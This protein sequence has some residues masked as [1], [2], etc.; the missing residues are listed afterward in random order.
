MMPTDTTRNRRVAMALLLAW[1]GLL[2]I[3][4]APATAQPPQAWMPWQ[5]SSKVD[6]LGNQ[7]DI[8]NGGYINQGT[9]STFRTAAVLT[10]NG[11][12]FNPTQSMMSADGL[13]FLFSTPNI[14][15]LKV[16]RRI[17]I[18]VNV[19]AVRYV[20]SFENLGA[21]QQVANIQLQYR[22]GRTQAQSVTT[23]LGGV[24]T[25][26]LGLGTARGVVIFTQPAQHQRTVLLDYGSPRSKLRPTFQ[27]NS[28]YQFHASFQLAV[29]GGKTVSIVHGVAQRSLASPPA[30]KE[31]AKLFK[32]FAARKWTRGV[33]G[34]VRRTIVNLRGGGYGTLDL[35]ALTQLDSLGV[36]RG[37]SDILAVGEETRVQ[38][39]AR[40]RRLAIETKYGQVEV[41]LER[42]AAIIGEQSADG[43]PRVFL[44]DG[45]I[46]FG[47]PTLDGLI[48]QLTSGLDMELSSSRLDRLVLHTSEDDGQVAPDVQALIE[49]FHGDRIA[50][51]ESPDVAI[52]VTTN[53]GQ[54]RVPLGDLLAC[55][56]QPETNG[57]RLVFADG[58]RLFA[59]MSDEV[60]LLRTV[61][62]GEIEIAPNEIRSLFA[63]Q[64]D[65]E[66]LDK[67]IEP[68]T[69]FVL[70]A[71]ENLLIGQI[72]SPEVHISAGG[73]SIPI[74]PNQ[75]R[76][77]RA[78]GD[79][80]DPQGKNR[81]RFEAE[82]WDG[83]VIQ[84]TL[85][86]RR[87]KIR[88]RDRVT[89]INVSDIVEIRVPVPTVPDSLR[90]QIAEHIRELGHEDFR[91][92]ETATEAL[93][94]LGYLA[95]PQLEE[96]LG[97][98]EDAEVRRRI[99]ELVA[100]LQ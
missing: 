6:T 73:Q 82:L 100:E 8:Y 52:K 30:G 57:H 7:W 70:L 88:E 99:E 89:E 26:N 96:A 95:R 48:I 29:P 74:P 2:M 42:V 31:L 38:G 24:L 61:E 33:E 97:V 64:L 51:R 93:S 59:Y 53:W 71:G 3:A 13:D 27:N 25:G 28:N 21:N 77:L 58:T 66:E 23:D 46:F 22:L 12:A 84:G 40:C 68:N 15:G 16:T 63:A 10:V 9:N 98:T 62:F 19:G 72:D 50:V 37:A 17:H 83:G 1:S 43:R 54:R 5:N 44:R 47:K 41:P 32:P 79:V 36:D 34:K 39:K 75:I 18:D 65:V 56:P 60:V 86:D 4:G 11:A 49:T 81:R 85:V 20:D 90:A 55:T 94:E 87:L 76:V 69:P 67:D 14:N 80:V 92:R 78:D 35:E 91:R 45:Q